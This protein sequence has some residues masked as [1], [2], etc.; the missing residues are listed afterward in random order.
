[1]QKDK[2]EMTN[3]F[4]DHNEEFDLNLF[5]MPLIRN[6]LLI[7]S[8]SLICFVIGCA[9]SFTLK[10]LWEGQFQI[11]LITKNNEPNPHSRRG[12][13]FIDVDFIQHFLS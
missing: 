3:S 1:M 4:G 9:Y 11:V 5:L 2:K 6:K 7:G 8:I 13:N 12:L 10:R